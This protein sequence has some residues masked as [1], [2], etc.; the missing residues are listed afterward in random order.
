MTDHYKVL[1]VSRSATQLEI[2][3][4]FLALAKLT[5]PDHNPGDAM[6]E[7]RFKIVSSAYDLLSDPAK[8][9]LHDLDLLAEE[10]RVRRV[11]SPA[12]RSVYSRGRAA[13]PPSSPTTP[14][15]PSQ[16]PPQPARHDVN[17][18]PGGSV[19]SVLGLLGLFGAALFADSRRTAWDP[20]ARRRRGRD[21]Q[22]RRTDS[23]W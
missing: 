11:P 4:A 13:S 17:A 1:G 18:N 8:R 21:G 7:T 5:H 14:P 23:W 6:K 12:P 2:R 22:F 9:A 20:R 15:Q 10:M 3:A 19:A 16:P